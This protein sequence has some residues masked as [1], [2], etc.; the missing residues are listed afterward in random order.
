MLV[1]VR[2]SSNVVAATIGLLQT[3][4][5]DPMVEASGTLVWWV[6]RPGTQVGCRADRA[7]RCSRPWVV[8][9]VAEGA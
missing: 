8:G 4:A 3:V 6:P 1:L 7:L 9:D 5:D 2:E